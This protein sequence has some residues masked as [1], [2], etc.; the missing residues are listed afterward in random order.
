M[1]NAFQDLR[2]EREKQHQRQNAAEVEA[3]VYEY[4]EMKQFWRDQSSGLLLYACL[5]GTV[6]TVGYFI[7]KLVSANKTWYG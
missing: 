7:S 6:E 4:N 5:H 1:L 3:E 2:F